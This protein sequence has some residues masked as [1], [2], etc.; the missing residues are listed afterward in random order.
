MVMI[1]KLVEFCQSNI[2]KTS[3]GTFNCLMDNP[4]VDVMDYECTNDCGVCS[5]TA[6]CIVE[7][8]RIAAKT[9]EQ[10]LARVLEE[11]Q[12][13]DEPDIFDYIKDSL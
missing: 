9:D 4:D 3:K 8:K 12:K 2:E 13:D 5:R 10:L 11:L 1:M 6:F 7:G